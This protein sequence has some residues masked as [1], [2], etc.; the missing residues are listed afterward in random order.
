MHVNEGQLALLDAL[1]ALPLPAKLLLGAIVAG[2]F[3]WLFVWNLKA[4]KRDAIKA[5]GRDGSKSE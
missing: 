2:L 1:K 4:D 3:A 5:A